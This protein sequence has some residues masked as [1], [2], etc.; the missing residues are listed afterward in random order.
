MVA[1]RPATARRLP[2]ALTDRTL[3]CPGAAPRTAPRPTP[4]PAPAPPRRRPPAWLTGGA[5]ARRHRGPGRRS[6]GAA[7]TG[8]LGGTET[9]IARDPTPLPGRGPRPP[10]GA[11]RR[12]TRRPPRPPSRRAARWSP[13]SSPA[14]VK[15]TVGSAA[16]TSA[17][18]PASWSTRRGR[19]LTN[20]HVRGDS[21]HGATV[22]LRR[23]HRGARRRARRA[24]R[25]PTW[26]CCSVDSRAAERRAR[27]PLGRSGDLVVGDP[28]DR[29]RQPVRARAHG[30]DRDRLGPEAH[31]H[32]RPTTSTS[33]TSSRPTPRSTRATRA[34]RCSTRAAGSWAS[35]PRSPRRAAATT[36][37]GSPS[38]STRSARSP[39]RSSRPGTARHAWLGVTG[40]TMTPAIAKALGAP[41]VRGVAVVGGRRPRGPA[42]KAGPARRRPA[43]PDADVPRGGDL[44]VAVDGRAVEDMADVSRAVSS[45]AVGEA[46]DAH[47]P[48]RRRGARVRVA[49]A[50]RPATSG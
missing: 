1:A 23:R 35:T 49:L 48:A 42:A 9:V 43:P 21:A 46:P 11:E 7:L 22:T 45:R 10:P 31:H 14:V 39:T 50:D 3:P 38:P 36:A 34:G 44:I 28:V 2:G 12:A 8:N 16:P 33:R 40:R 6:G 20:A 25:A 4:Y 41:D 47:R 5:A 13:T 18:A 19:V 29:D 27:S 32:R 24:T 26:P 15:V 30:H 17:W 37:S